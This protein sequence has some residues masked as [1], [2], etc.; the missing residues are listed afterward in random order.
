MPKPPTNMTLSDSESN[1][2][3]VGQANKN[4]DCDPTFTGASTSNEPHLLTQGDLNN[5]D[6]DLN[7]TER[8]A[9]LSFKR[10]CKDF[11][12]NHKAANCQDVVQELLTSS[13][14]YGMQYESENP[15]FGVPLEF[16]PRKSRQSQ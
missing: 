11:L 1:D 15:L 6:E 16:F 10:I 12:G 9:W 14:S 4:M 5:I 7:E 13:Q 8:N 3:V 2:E